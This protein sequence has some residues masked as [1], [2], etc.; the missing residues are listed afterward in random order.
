M[1]KNKPFPNLSIDN[2][3]ENESLVR[4]AAES[5]EHLND[6]RNFLS[7]SLTLLKENGK[8]LIKTYLLIL[9]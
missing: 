4:A 9:K 5:F 8:Y 6:W 7:K 1:Y 2:F 3:V